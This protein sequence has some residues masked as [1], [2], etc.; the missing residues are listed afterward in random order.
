MAKFNVGAVVHLKS[1]GP[2]MTIERIY[3]SEVTG[4]MAFAYAQLKSNYPQSEIFYNCRW[5][6]DN[7]KLENSTF[8]EEI[9]EA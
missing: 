3:D 7:N 1:G 5:F 2:D 9:L 6:T 8:A 4:V